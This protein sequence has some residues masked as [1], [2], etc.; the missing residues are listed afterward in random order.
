MSKQ[1]EKVFRE[2][3]K[4][5]DE[6][7]GSGDK[8]TDEMKDSVNGFMAQYQPSGQEM[9]EG[10]AETSDDFLEL[11]ESASSKKEALKYAKKAV[12]LDPDN[13]D[14]SVL[15][16]G[17]SAASLEKLLEKYENL[18][19][20]AEKKLKADGLFADDCI[21]D[22]WGL[23]QTRPYMRL[24]DRYSD[25]L[26]RCGRMRMA[27]SG[28]E[29]MLKLCKNDNL[30]ARYRLMHLFAFLEDEK[31]ALDLLAKYPDEESTQFLLPLSVLYY[32]LG[33]LREANKYLRR[34][35]EINKDTRKFFNGVVGGDLDKY[36]EDMDLYGYSPFTIEEFLVESEENSFLFA[37]IPTYFDWALRK[38]KTKS[39]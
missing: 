26:V 15:A 10:I 20:A 19:E 35:C 39:K 27:V 37:G 32:K 36:Y 14:A 28:Y 24:L 3:H 30:G 4:Y 18:M 17:I 34:L 1:T 25:A 6:N 29:K 21:G 23:F 11:A 22:F 9:T 33:D 31:S 13:L 38:L 8:T 16:A 7:G 5:I 12:E 2:P